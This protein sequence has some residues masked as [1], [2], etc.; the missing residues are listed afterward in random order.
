MTKIPRKPAE[1][2]RVTVPLRLPK[3]MRDW[4]DNQPHTRAEL[5]E[6]ALVQAYKIKPPKP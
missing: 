3:W 6:H 5:I 4:L 1:M 2:Q